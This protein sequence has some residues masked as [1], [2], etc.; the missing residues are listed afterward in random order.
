LFISF[1]LLFL[2]GGGLLLRAMYYQPVYF[3]D[4]WLES[5]DTIDGAIS[6]LNARISTR[7]KD[8]TTQQQSQTVCV[9]VHGFSASSFEFEAFKKSILE[10][11][12]NAFFSSIVLGGHGRNYDAFKNATYEDWLAPIVTELT[13]L[14]S[15]G[16]TNIVLFGV[17]TGASG[18]LHLAL[19]QKLNHVPIRQIILMDPYVLPTN[20]TLYLVPWLKY[21]ITNTRL[22]D[23][24]VLGTQYWYTNRP[25][26]SLHELLKLVKV[27]QSDLTNYSGGFKTPM[28][29]YTANGDPT[30]DT[31]GA[32]MILNALGADVVNINR[33]ESSHHVLIEPTS[34]KDWSASDQRQYEH[35]IDEI[36]SLIQ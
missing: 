8:P 23:V 26:Q 5:E 31:R 10:K 35:I 15:K 3:E 17:S 28:H 20:K 22:E 12:S 34:K 14:S 7:I 11:D 2:V 9:L 30:A 16:Y 6:D 1:F 21:V 32:D 24:G 25:A 36:F 27:T 29:I 4:D 13:A 18:I 19:N 33:Y